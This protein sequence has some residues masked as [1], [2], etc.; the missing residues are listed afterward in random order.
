M[1]TQTSRPVIRKRK[2]RIEVTSYGDVVD[3]KVALSP[4]RDAISRIYGILITIKRGDKNEILLWPED[5]GH[6]YEARYVAEKLCERFKIPYT[7]KTYR[8]DKFSEGFI[9]RNDWPNKRWLPECET[10]SPYLGMAILCC[11]LLSLLICAF[12]F[13]T[14]YARPYIP[15]FGIILTII[16]AI[17]GWKFLEKQLSPPNFEP[18]VLWLLIILFIALIPGAI[19]TQYYLNVN[20][21]FFWGLPYLLGLINAVGGAAIVY[22]G[23]FA[24]FFLIMGGWAAYDVWRKIKHPIE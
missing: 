14:E 18:F 11:G 17:M 16:G 20:N 9:R 12:L 13:M 24:A 4:K 7:G 19:A 22:L 8:T 3:V 2:N 6:M 1:G 10:S 15:Y 23:P 5:Y 21:T